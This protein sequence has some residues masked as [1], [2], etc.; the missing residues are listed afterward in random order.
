[1]TDPAGFLKP[2]S[3]RVFG[4]RDGLIQRCVTFAGPSVLDPFSDG[5]DAWGRPGRPGV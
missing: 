3:L 2:H 1:M 5:L 4:V